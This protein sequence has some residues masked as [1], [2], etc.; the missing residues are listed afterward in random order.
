MKKLNALFYVL[1]GAMAISCM[2]SDDSINISYR[3]SDRY[4]SMD[5][6]FSKSKTREVEE[7]MDHQ[8]GSNMSFA[9]SSIDGTISLDDHTTFYMQKSPGVLEIKLDKRENSEEAY[10]RIKYMCEGIKAVVQN[11]P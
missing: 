11:A 8:I 4:Y 6:H 10:H 5:A 3:N 9:N 2:G 1:A 7:Y